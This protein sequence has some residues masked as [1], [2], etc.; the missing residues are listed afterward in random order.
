[1]TT[2]I[3]YNV[4]ITVIIV[5][6]H[7]VDGNLTVIIVDDKVLIKLTWSSTVTTFSLRKTNYPNW[8]WVK[9]S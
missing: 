8:L 6:F 7:N 3:L 4:V 5:E 9:L 2:N 1:M